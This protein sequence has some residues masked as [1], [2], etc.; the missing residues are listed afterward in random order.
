MPRSLNNAECGSKSTPCGQTSFSTQPEITHMSLKPM[1]RYMLH[2]LCTAAEHWTNKLPLLC[3]MAE[4]P[5]VAMTFLVKFSGSN[6]SHMGEC[7]RLHWQAGDLEAGALPIFPLW[8]Q[9][10]F[11]ASFQPGQGAETNRQVPQP[12][13]CYYNKQLEGHQNQTL[14]LVLQTLSHSPFIWIHWFVTSCGFVTSFFASYCPET[15]PV[16]PQTDTKKGEAGLTA[17]SC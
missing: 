3:W 13:P 5:G 8:K 14:L 10:I 2:W 15:L 4:H 6:G 11:Y 1:A 17:S 16:K 9:S 7:I 12:L